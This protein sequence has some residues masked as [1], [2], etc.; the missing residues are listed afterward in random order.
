MTVKYIIHINYIQQS[1]ELYVLHLSGIWIPV[2]KA[3]S[4]DLSKISSAFNTSTILPSIFCFSFPLCLIKYL[5]LSNM[6][7]EALISIRS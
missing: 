4:G 6:I 1:F 5:T 3:I 7:F 2:Y